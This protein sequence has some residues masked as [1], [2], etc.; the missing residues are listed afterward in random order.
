MS[1][2]VTKEQAAQALGRMGLEPSV[3]GECLSLEEFAQLS[4]ILCIL[5]NDKDYSNTL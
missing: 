2:G 5:M 4:D 3:R 1:L